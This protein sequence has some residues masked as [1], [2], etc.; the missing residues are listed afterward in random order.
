MEGE[1][2]PAGKYK[3][4]FFNTCDKSKPK[5]TGK[6]QKGECNNIYCSTIGNSKKLELNPRGSTMAHAHNGL[7]GSYK[8]EWAICVCPQGVVSRRHD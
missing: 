6:A 5:D 4:I 2:E 8:M 3:S 1:T 7:Q